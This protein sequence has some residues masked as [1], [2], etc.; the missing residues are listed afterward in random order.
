[1]TAD[2]I[3]FKRFEDEDENDDEDDC[4]NLAPRNPY[5]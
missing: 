1:M 4:K 3:V 2:L 5:K